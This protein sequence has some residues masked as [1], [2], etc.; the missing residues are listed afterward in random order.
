MNRKTRNALVEAGAHEKLIETID[1]LPGVI[2]GASFLAAHHKL[3]IY[4]VEVAIYYNN[5]KRKVAGAYIYGMINGD[6]PVNVF[7]AENFSLHVGARGGI[8]E[9]I[10]RTFG[11]TY[12]FGTKTR[13]AA[14]MYGYYHRNDRHRKL[15]EDVE[16]HEDAV[17]VK[18]SRF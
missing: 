16:V 18:V 2:V 11:G 5:K 14:T 12:S 10:L 9:F 1:M 7:L 8:K 15:N 4:E 6:P 3:R 13:R 17:N